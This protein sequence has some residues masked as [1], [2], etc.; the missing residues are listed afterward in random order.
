VLGGKCAPFFQNVTDT[1]PL[2]SVTVVGLSVIV[3]G[4]EVCACASAALET[5]HSQIAEIVARRIRLIGLGL[6]RYQ[7]EEV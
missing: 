2:L 3:T 6:P 5:Q 7:I 4:A 1:M